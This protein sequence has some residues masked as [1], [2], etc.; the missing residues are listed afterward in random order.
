MNIDY[1]KLE[2]TFRFDVHFKLE[3]LEFGD[4]SIFITVTDARDSS[5]VICTVN[6][7]TFFKEYSV[8]VQNQEDLKY[9]KILESLQQ[10]LWDV[11]RISE[12]YDDTVLKQLYDFSVSLDYNKFKTYVSFDNS[13]RLVAYSSSKQVI[14]FT[15]DNDGLISVKYFLNDETESHMELYNASIEQLIEYMNQRESNFGH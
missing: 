3:Y 7:G 13:V 11:C 8:M 1:N 10:Q 14:W 15:I 9:S 2:Y 6:L 4:H 12:K 5:L